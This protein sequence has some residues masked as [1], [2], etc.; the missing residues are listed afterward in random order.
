MGYPT[1]LLSAGEVVKVD[2]KPHWLYFLGPA[3]LTIAAIVVAIVVVLAWDVSW[4]SWFVAIAII[5]GACWLVGRLVKWLNTYFVVTNDK[6]IY[7]SGVFRRSGVQIP[8]ERVN[9]VNFEQNLIERMVG[10]GDLII[11]SGGMGGPAKFTD[12]RHPERV[13]VLIHDAIEENAR[14]LGAY[15]GEMPG[16]PVAPAGGSPMPPPPP[17]VAPDVTAQLERLEGMLQRGTITKEEFD[18]QKAKLLG[19]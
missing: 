8:L 1:K 4:A 9:S 15:V 18:V 2:L 7:R 10:A 3:T 14:G 12:V 11:E 17:V 5:F 16:Q 6:V 13:Q 19:S